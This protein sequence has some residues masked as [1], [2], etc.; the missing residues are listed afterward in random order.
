MAVYDIFPT[1]LVIK[2]IELNDKQIFDLTV[3]V[4]SIFL[5][6]Q[7]HNDN[8]TGSSGSNSWA[9]PF[10]VF[11]QKNL[12]IFP[13]LN[14]VKEIF[15]DGFYELAE[16]HVNNELT[17]DMVA[18]LFADNFG[19][20]PVMKTGDSLPVHTHPGA[21]ASAVFYLTDVDNEKDG[22]MLCLRDPSWHT[23]LGFRNPMEHFVETKAGRLVVFPTQIWH[24]VRPYYGEEDRMTIVG[25]LSYIPYEAVKNVNMKGD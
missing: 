4:Q 10:P 22:G 15:I 2:D 20:L 19:Q 12:E 11:T 3:A 7:I 6:N 16:A 5:D 21:V 9:E 25:N 24:E 13:V 23:T 14:D 8:E 17:R 1:K 18:S